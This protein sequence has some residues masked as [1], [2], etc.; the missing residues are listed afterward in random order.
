[1]EK[2]TTMI[3]R[4]ITGGQTG[5]DQAGWRSARAAGIATG[6]LMPRGFLTEDGPRPDFARNFG[7]EEHHAADPDGRTVA[8]VLA[9]DATLVFATEPCGPGTRRTIAT[10]H[11]TGRPCRVVHLGP[12]GFDTTPDDVAA[13]IRGHPVRILNV[14]GDRASTAP[15]LGAW[16]EAFLGEV[17]R[18]CSAES[19]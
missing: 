7:A 17:F 16:V 3:A 10:C 6:G 5:A 15:G 18:K 8:N 14:A 2:P 4:V 12:A 9:A 1:M 19:S 11:A 13:W